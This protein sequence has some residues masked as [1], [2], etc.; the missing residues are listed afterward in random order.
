MTVWIGVRPRG[1]HGGVLFSQVLTPER[2]SNL[3]IDKLDEATAARDE[4]AIEYHLN[5]LARHLARFPDDHPARP[6]L[7]A[8]L[9]Q[10]RGAAV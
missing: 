9:D 2:L 10:L 6:R 1:D 5:N 4:P 7:T 3:T 8:M